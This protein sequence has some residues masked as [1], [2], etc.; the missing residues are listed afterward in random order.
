MSNNRR[1][2]LETEIKLLY[3]RATIVE[4]RV[5]TATMASRFFFVRRQRVRWNSGTLSRLKT[6]SGSIADKNDIYFFFL[7][8]FKIRRIFDRRTSKANVNWTRRPYDYFV[9]GNVRRRTYGTPAK[10]DD[11]NTYENGRVDIS[12]LVIAATAY[13]N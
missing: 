5:S 3:R 1:Q 13:G 4:I 6:V 11:Q 12:S 7:S 2:I 9:S 10:S 8:R